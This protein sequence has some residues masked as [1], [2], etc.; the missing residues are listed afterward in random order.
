MRMIV[1]MPRSPLA[2]SLRAAMGA[3]ALA[4]LALGLTACSIPSSTAAGKLNVLTSFYPLEFVAQQIG[5]DL[6]TVTNLT[7]RGGE[8]HELE[9]APATIRKIDSADVV[10][11]LSG[12]QP[13][14]DSA[15]DPTGQARVLDI[16]P[17]AHLEPFATLSQASED[18]EGP[19]HTHDAHDVHD[20]HD[21]GPLDPHFWLDPNRLADVA[22][23][24]GAELAEADPDHA[25]DFQTRTETLVRSLTDLDEAFTT[26]LQ[27]CENRTVVT[28]HAA[29]SYLTDKYGLEQISVA[30]L[31]PEAEPSPAKLRKVSEQIASDGIQTVFYESSS[32]AK[33]ADVLAHDLGISSAVL[34][35][36]ETLTT[37]DSNYLTVM[38]ENLTALR[39]ALACN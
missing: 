32:S 11:Y 21:H 35:P 24:V 15:I 27:S 29:F 18:S 13:A 3:L 5:G 10:V 25:S 39:T 37:P 33:V 7:P 4:G 8:P 31:D 23:H 28:S 38:N 34:D 20:G 36:L 14:I 30:G 19:D 2:R 12:F 16:A 9:L 6:I 17:F 1:M 26:G 22:E